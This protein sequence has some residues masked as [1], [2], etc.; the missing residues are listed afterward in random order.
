MKKLRFLILIAIM[1]G[2]ILQ[3]ISLARADTLS[4]LERRQ[5]ELD[6]QIEANK[7][8]LTQKKQEIK[9]LQSMLN[10][11]DSQIA[12]TEQNINLSADKI[13]ITVQKIDKLQAEIDQKQKELETQKQNLF[14]TMR[15]MYETPQRSTI[16]IVIGSNSLSEVVDRAQYIESLNYQIETSINTIT[17]LK[18]QLESE[19]NQ[20]DQERV[21]L[22]KQKA[23]LIETK[24]GLDVQKNQKSQLLSQNEAQKSSYQEVLT[25]LVSE[26]TRISNEIYSTR[27][28]SGGISFGSSG[29]PFGNIDVPDP[30]LFLTRECTSYAAWYWNVKLGKSWYNT[31]PGRGSARYWDEIARTLGYTV[32]STPRV[33]AFVV[34]RGPLFSGD[35]WGHVAIVEMVN[36][37]GTIDISEMN[38]VSYSYSYRTGVRPENYGAYY[39]VY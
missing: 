4:D 32:S 15:V 10:N 25:Q 6:K 20:L 21:D 26:H 22:E 18:S 8:A 3:P 1:A 5:A 34:W 2:F 27:M 38:W 16:E 24:N 19:R 31:Q 9:D 39:Y 37:D 36:P 13:K 35:R 33:N 14:E 17:Q 29:Y 30:W 12:T 23:A 11:L 7:N 28:A